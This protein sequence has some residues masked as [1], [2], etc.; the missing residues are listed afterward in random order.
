M[1]HVLGGPLDHHL[2]G[3]V[4]LLYHRLVWLDRSHIT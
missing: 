4:D 3:I 2:G 1:A